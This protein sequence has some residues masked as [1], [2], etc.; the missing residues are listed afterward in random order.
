VQDGDTVVV[1]TKTVAGYVNLSNLL[2]DLRATD[3][4]VSISWK[5]DL[6][7]DTT[8]INVYSDVLTESDVDTAISNNTITKDEYI[9]LAQPK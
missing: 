8:T 9:S 4:N 3:A 5:V 6:N 7:T 2:S 1:I